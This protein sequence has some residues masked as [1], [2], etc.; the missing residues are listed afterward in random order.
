MAKKI[1][2]PETVKVL[3]CTLTKCVDIEGGEPRYECLVYNKKG[4]DVFE[5]ELRCS[6]NTMSTAGVGWQLSACSNGNIMCEEFFSN[7]HPTI[8]A[9]VKDMEGQILAVINEL[10][11]YVTGGHKRKAVKPRAKKK[12]AKKTAKKAR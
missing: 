3:G 12:A 8:K 9:A 7:D 6:R 2:Y 4:E 10:N 11:L 5:L 1:K